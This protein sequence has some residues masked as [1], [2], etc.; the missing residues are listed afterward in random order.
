MCGSCW[1]FGTAESIEGAWYLKTHNLIPISQ[2]AFMDCSWGYGNNACDGG[3]AFRFE[4]ALTHFSNSV[5]CS[6]YQWAL[7]NGGFVPSET[8]YGLYLMSDGLC[9]VQYSDDD[10]ADEMLGVR[11]TCLF[12]AQ[13]VF[14]QT[15]FQ[16]T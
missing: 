3:E 14:F 5:C 4:F 1:S 16:H 8:A 7:D 6:A 9:H 12:L 11:I 2:Q 15:S 13:F 10:D